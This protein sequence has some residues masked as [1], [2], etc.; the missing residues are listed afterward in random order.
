MRAFGLSVID[1]RPKG[2]SRAPHAWFLACCYLVYI[3]PSLVSDLHSRTV[4]LA[5]SVYANS[6]EAQEDTAA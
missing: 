1:C 6:I 3:N 2:I 5:H 4:L